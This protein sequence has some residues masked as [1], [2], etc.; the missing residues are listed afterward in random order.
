VF[1]S[2]FVGPAPAALERN[3][4]EQQH[5]NAAGSELAPLAC[6][7][8]G[9]IIYGFGLDGERALIVAFTTATASKMTSARTARASPEL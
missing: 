8:V 7:P 6:G 1:I 5:S 3:T 4:D 2:C 9:H